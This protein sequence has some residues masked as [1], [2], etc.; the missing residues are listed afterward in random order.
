MGGLEEEGKGR[1]EYRSTA[2]HGEARGEEGRGGGGARSSWTRERSTSSVAAGLFSLA[3]RFVGGGG[4]GGGGGGVEGRARARAR[5]ER[6]DRPC[7]AVWLGSSGWSCAGVVRGGMS[8]WCEGSARGGEGGRGVGKSRRD[9]SAVTVCCE[10]TRELRGR[11]GPRGGRR[12][13]CV[14]EDRPVLQAL[15]EQFGDDRID[16]LRASVNS[17]APPPRSRSA[18]PVSQVGC[19]PVCGRIEAAK[20][21]GRGKGEGRVGRT[22]DESRTGQDRR[23]VLLE[24]VGL[25]RLRVGRH[26]QTDRGRERDREM[27]RSASGRGTTAF[28]ATAWVFEGLEGD[29][30]RERPVR[31]SP[32]VRCTPPAGGRARSACRR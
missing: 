29:A 21:K 32:L 15:S 30:H 3:L 13:F 12:T 7:R 11:G 31:S 25:Q 8:S 28:A 14:A 6:V 2:R 4:G 5:V 1:G 23:A 22:E 9:V 19:R 24:D 10:E 20:G 26:L 27:A 17:R 16:C 18:R